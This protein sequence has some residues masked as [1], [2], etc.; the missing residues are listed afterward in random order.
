MH[1][2]RRAMHEDWDAVGVWFRYGTRL[3]WFI[4]AT[5]AL[6]LVGSAVIGRTVSAF[7]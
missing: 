4:V 6:I 7:H 5:V 2:D 1:L 3:N